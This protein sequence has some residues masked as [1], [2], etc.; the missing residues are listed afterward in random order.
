[1]N[2]QKAVLLHA[3]DDVATALTPLANGDAVTVSGHGRSVD[4]AL[5]DD[6]PF[7]HKFALRA[8]A[9]GEE[10]L[11]YGLPIGRA[12]QDI[13]PGQWVHV[14]NCRSERFGHRHQLYGVN[15]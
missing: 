12:L 13:R 14:H 1:M 10:V 4:V 2:R 6:I 15:A 8:L 11:K 7:A 3:R 9:A 5:R